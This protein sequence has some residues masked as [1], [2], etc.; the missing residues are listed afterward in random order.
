VQHPVEFTV[1][2]N[3]MLGWQVLSNKVILS[4]PANHAYAV[5]PKND[6]ARRSTKLTCCR[7]AARA[8]VTT[9]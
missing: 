7:I 5:R 8:C 1:C 2:N 4:M 3:L 9:L 6:C